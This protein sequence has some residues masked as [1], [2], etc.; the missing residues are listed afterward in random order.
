MPGYLAR[1]VARVAPGVAGLCVLLLGVG[2]AMAATAR[3]AFNCKPVV[4]YKQ[5]TDKHLLYDANC[6]VAPCVGSDGQNYGCVE[7]TVETG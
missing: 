7:F 1:R 3:I 2:E 6:P 5:S 4:R